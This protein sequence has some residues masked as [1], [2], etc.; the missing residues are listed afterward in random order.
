MLVGV[1]ISAIIFGASH[2]YEGVPRMILI[3]IYGL[4]FGLL[5]WWRKSLRAGM[6][7]H[8]WHDAISGVFLRLLK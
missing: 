7:A 3:G 8:A 1:L 2:G 4:M 6:M 5:A